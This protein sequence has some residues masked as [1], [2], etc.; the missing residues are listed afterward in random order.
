MV[1]DVSNHPTT[2]YAPKGFHSFAWRSKH[3]R[4]CLATV[5]VSLVAFVALAN[6]AMPQ[7]DGQRGALE[8]TVL[9]EWV[10][11]AYDWEG[12]GE[13][14]QAWIDAGLYIAENCV[15]AGIK[16]WEETVFVTIPRWAPGVPA[17]LNRVV[18]REGSALLEPFPAVEGQMLNNTQGLK[19]VQGPPHSF[20]P[21]PS[22]PHPLSLSHAHMDTRFSSVH[23]IAFLTVSS[24][25]SGTQRL[26]IGL[27]QAGR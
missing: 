24:K 4:W 26:C 11:M 17:T 21:L 13:D 20:R 1:A 5:L 25:S 22:L 16:Q 23:F 8:G 3:M 10:E 9:Y 27:T 2:P 6:A 19:N 12:M 18:E 14:E 15:L 7:R